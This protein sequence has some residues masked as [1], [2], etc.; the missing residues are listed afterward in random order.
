MKKEDKK[1]NVIKKTKVVKKV[2]KEPRKKR[3]LKIKPITLI[4]TLLVSLVLI[5]VSYYFLGLMLTV[6]LTVGIILILLIGGWLDKPKAKTKRRKIM[7]II[8]MIILSLGIIG[9][10]GASAFMVYIVKNAPDFKQEL[11]S[12]QEATIIYDSD[13]AEITKLGAEFRENIEYDHAS[14]IFIDA[15]IATEDSR[16]FQ[17]NGFDLMRFAKA[18]A[19]QLMGNSNAGGG[20]TLTMQ[21]AKN[22]FTSTEDEGIQGIIRKFTDIYISIFQL[23]RNYTKEQIIEFYINNNP[24]GA[25]GKI[26][27]VQEASQYFFGKDAKDLNISEAA[28]LAGMYQAPTSYD[29]FKNPNNATK[30]RSTVLYLMQRHGYITKEE[31]EIAESIPVESLLTS[32]AKT[33]S[34]YQSYIDYV[35]DEVKERWGVDPNTTPML[36]Y[37]NMDRKKQN[38]VNDILS[39]KTFKWKD[40]YIQS[41][42]AV[43]DSN[44][45]KIIALGGGRNRKPGDWNYA[46]D[47][48]RQI[49]ST[50]KPFF[51]YAPGMEYNNWS[52]YT[53]FDDEKGYTYSNGK[54]ISNYD[55]KWEGIITLRRALSNSRNIPSLKAF[56]QVDNKKIIELVTSVGIK[57]EISNG[58][59]HE[60]HAIGAFEGENSPLVM[61]GAY[62]IFSN[63]GYFYEPFAVSKVTFRATGE[64]YEYASPKEKV[65]SDST[66]YMIT[67][68]LKMVPNSNTKKGLGKDIFAAKTGTTNVDSKTKDDNDLPSSIVR[69][70]WIDGYTHDTVISIWIGYDKL[71]SK[72]YLN[73][74][75]DGQL[76]HKLLNAVGKVCFNHD[77]VN[78]KQ[79]KSVV[80][81]NVEKLSDPPM[82]PSANTPEDQITSE[83]FKRGTEP[84]Q[85]STKYLTLSTPTNFSVKYHNNS[86]TL[87][88]NPVTDLQY[89]EGGKLGYYIYFNNT[90]EPLYFTES[91]SYTMTNY[92]SYLGTYYVKAGYYDTTVGMSAPA[93]YELKETV[94]Y[95]LSLNGKETTTY[96][97]NENI[98]QSLYNG[99]MV[100]LTANGSS[101]TSSATIKTT[102]KDSNGNVVTSID[103]TKAGTY[104]ITYNVTYNGYNGS[105]SNKIQIVDNTPPSENP[106][107]KPNNEPNDK[108]NDNQN[109]N[110]NQQGGGN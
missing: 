105:I 109:N 99:S 41:G 48:F 96:N 37:T 89:V 90:E 9:L 93:S 106:N 2:N 76:R 17:H 46:T 16:F 23:E 42:I 3:S 54:S 72:Y 8:C 68:I 60:A 73:Y 39:G 26:F 64:S 104:I 80:R 5:G 100:S 98:S 11:L 88:W 35:V 87:S 74:N 61:A 85:V 19:G 45:G 7:K 67:D 81:V 70:Y 58:Y 71:S 43:L 107:D 69:D 51:D 75:K 22:T 25:G 78:F 91:T 36:I 32:D 65:I 63:G 82:L 55:G 47:T 97:I 62:Q 10:L 4:I 18:T 86:V 34:P 14:E 38:G 77:N 20:S 57:P 53:L 103:N 102:I 27:G 108:P 30:R 92:S 12:K 33:A 83:L 84:T 79:P 110:N 44:S 66:A 49:G 94:E 28:L 31:R 40:E 52:T 15:L 59:I 56:Q 13:G 50:A 1:N 95:K 29:P 101:V 6:I 24:L 21:V